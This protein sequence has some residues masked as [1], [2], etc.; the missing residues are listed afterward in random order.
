MRHCLAL[1]AIKKNDVAGCGL[2]FAPQPAQADPFD[3]ACDLAP[4]QRV[5]R[6][7][8]TEFFS[9]RLGQLRTADANALTCFD[10]ARRRGTVQLCR[11]ATGC[12]S[13]GVT[14]R[15]A[16][17]LFTGIGPGA[18]LAFSAAI[19]PPAKSLRQRRTVSSRTPNASAM[20]GPVHPASVS[21]TARARVRF[22]AI[23]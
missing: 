5:P 12:S 22:A 2:L 1:V 13:K 23:T 6:P 4:L 19:P 11:S 3:L 8:P 9:Q 18:T 17:S 21:S 16:V 10:L 14:T 15:N 20:R 7:P